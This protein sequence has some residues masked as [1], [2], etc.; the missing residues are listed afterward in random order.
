MRRNTISS[1]HDFLPPETRLHQFAKCKLATFQ[2]HNLVRK[3]S[4]TGS[5]ECTG[6]AKNQHAR[7]SNWNS[8]HSKKCWEILLLYSRISLFLS[9]E[10]ELRWYFRHLASGKKYTKEKRVHSSSEAFTSESHVYQKSSRDYFQ[11]EKQGNDCEIFKYE[12]ES[13]LRGWVKV[14]VSYPS[15]MVDSREVSR[16]NEAEDFSTPFE[17]PF[18][19]PPSRHAIWGLKKAKIKKYLSLIPVTNSP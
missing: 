11:A 10:H 12:L 18:F 15:L 3:V 17:S 8:A 19:D 9:A 16:N 7:F 6:I 5:G 14:F 1:L 4:E 13:D 2:P